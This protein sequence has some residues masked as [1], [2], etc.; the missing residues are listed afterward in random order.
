M[1]KITI[2]EAA[3]A[4]TVL[5]EGILA[6][7]W[8]DELEQTWL[9]L[10]GKHF[11]RLVVVDLSGVTFVGPEGKKVL[12]WIYEEGAELRGAD[13]MNKAIIEEIE[14]KHE[15]ARRAFQWFHRRGHGT[16]VAGARR[17]SL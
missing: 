1:L 12:G 14:Q 15:A 7:P 9:T 4:R 8:V 2:K 5:L 16:Q 6:G 10:I 17:G 11:D 13:V 3:E